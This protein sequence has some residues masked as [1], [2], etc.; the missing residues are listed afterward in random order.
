MP[1]PVSY[2]VSPAPLVPREL[3]AIVQLGSLG[4]MAA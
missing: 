4:R 3:R 1:P 2:S